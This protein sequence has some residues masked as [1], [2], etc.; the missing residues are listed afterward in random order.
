MVMYLHSILSYR[1]FGNWKNRSI[2]CNNYITIYLPAI[3]RCF[4]IAGF[5][6]SKRRDA[7][8]HKRKSMLPLTNRWLYAGKSCNGK[9]K[10][11]PGTIRTGLGLLRRRQLCSTP[12]RGVPLPGCW[13]SISF[14]CMTC[15]L[16]VIQIT[17]SAHG[18]KRSQT[19]LTI[20]SY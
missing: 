16:T 14:P 11:T 2:P 19:A 8:S 1:R 12:R 9:P 6:F 13:R 4:R 17:T 18:M 10:N 20:C 5:L 3:L 15:A 7:I